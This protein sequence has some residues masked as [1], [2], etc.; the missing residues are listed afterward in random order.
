MFSLWG[1]LARG[2]DDVG[3]GG[4]GVSLDRV[5]RGSGSCAGVDADT[6]EVAAKARFKE[7]AR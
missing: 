2:E 5:G 6:T 4:V 3:T 1:V 7:G